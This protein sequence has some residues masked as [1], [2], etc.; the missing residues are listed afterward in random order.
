MRAGRPQSCRRA[1]A[2]GVFPVWEINESCQNPK[3]LSVTDMM[4]NSNDRTALKVHYTST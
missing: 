2:L 1:M 4:S 3:A